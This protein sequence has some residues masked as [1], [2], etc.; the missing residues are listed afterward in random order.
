V[1]ETGVAADLSMLDVFYF[2]QLP[3]V[4]QQVHGQTDSILHGVMSCGSAG[5]ETDAERDAGGPDLLLLSC[6]VGLRARGNMAGVPFERPPDSDLR[7]TFTPLGAD[8]SITFDAS[9]RSTNLVFPPGYLAGQA[10]GSF[11]PLLFSADERL[12]GLIGLLETKIMAPGFASRL[13]VD[14]VRLAIATLPVR[15]DPAAV[16]AG[17]KRIHLTPRRLRRVIDFI[18]AHLED[19][20]GLDGMTHI[21]D[22]SPFHFSRVFKLD[23]G[24]TFHKFVTEQ[25]LRRSRNLLADSNLSIAKVALAYG[26]ANQSH[27][28]SALTRAV[29]ISHGRYRRTSTQ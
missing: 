25:R 11:A 9:A 29:G 20:I 23:K 4:L 19:C 15:L 28:A 8:S 3:R 13:L 2:S 24:S 6:G 22:L 7:T 12:A 1:P 16:A 18:G 27:L 17:G 5:T 14:S 10:H 26:F 21:A